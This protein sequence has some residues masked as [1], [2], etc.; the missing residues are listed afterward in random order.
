MFR[1]AS[2][3]YF[4]S[5]F[6]RRSGG[7][8]CYPVVESYGTVLRRHSVN[9]NLQMPWKPLGSGDRNER[10]LRLNVRGERREAVLQV[11][12]RGRTFF[13]KA[14]RS[15]ST[16]TKLKKSILDRLPYD[17]PRQ[18]AQV[19]SHSIVQYSIVHTSGNTRASSLDPSTTHRGW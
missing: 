17:N 4:I 13:S 16:R 5:S 6:S 7:Q 1:Y 8:C 15:R 12:E 11:T 3:C 9:H 19:P 14:S 10:L 2:S 18:A